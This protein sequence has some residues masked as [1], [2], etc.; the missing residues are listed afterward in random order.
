MSAPLSARTPQQRERLVQ[1]EGTRPHSP[2]HGEFSAHFMPPLRCPVRALSV[3]RRSS[4]SR[5]ATQQTSASTGTQAGRPSSR[6]AV[7]SL[8]KGEI[9]ATATEIPSRPAGGVPRSCPWHCCPQPAGAVGRRRRGRTDDGDRDDAA[10]PR[11]P[12]PSRPRHFAPAFGP[13]V[14]A[15]APCGQGVSVRKRPRRAN[16]GVRG[17][18]NPSPDSAAPP[19]PPPRERGLGGEG[20][21]GGPGCEGRRPLSIRY[22]PLSGA[23]CGAEPIRAEVC[24]CAA[25]PHVVAQP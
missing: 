12:G 23:P 8:S 18:A 2:L 22:L 7:A 13:A 24:P 17:R 5:R 10:V 16:P 25:S 20:G 9:A 6:E 14:R 21:P 4:W 19:L 3:E 15:G 11:P 1:V